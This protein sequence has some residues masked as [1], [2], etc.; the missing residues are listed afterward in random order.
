[1]PGTPELPCTI[2]NPQT[3]CNVQYNGPASQRLHYHHA[4]QPAHSYLPANNHLALK[5]PQSP[6]GTPLH[7]IP[8]SWRLRAAVRPPAVMRMRH[9]VL[10]TTSDFEHRFTDFTSC[11]AASALSGLLEFLNVVPGAPP[12]VVKWRMGRARHPTAAVPPCPP[13]PETIPKVCHI[14]VSV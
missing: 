1:M 14:Q 6:G 3:A 11:Q 7:D 4:C 9:G 2:C 13:C 8:L 12:V 10:H 5:A